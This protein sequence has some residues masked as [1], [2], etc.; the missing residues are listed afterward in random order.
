MTFVRAFAALCC[1]L[2]AG[3]VVFGAGLSLL[4]TTA[5]ALLPVVVGVLVWVS[6]ED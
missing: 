1:V 2:V 5:Y 4:P 3:L 6:P